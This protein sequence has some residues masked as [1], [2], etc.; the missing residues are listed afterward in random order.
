[1][2]ILPNIVYP[3]LV[4]FF[5]KELPLLLPR[6]QP[7]F[8]LSLCNMGEVVDYLSVICPFR[9]I[10]PLYWFISESFVPI[11]CRRSGNILSFLSVIVLKLRRCGAVSA[12]PIFYQVM[13]GQ[14]YCRGQGVPGSGSQ[15]G[16]VG[17]LTDSNVIGCLISRLYAA[18]CTF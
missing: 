6:A 9:V 11:F 18:T 4:R 16:G 2:G 13:S 15:G 8:F 3:L 10:C 14:E 1:M 7:P 12:R 5:F 17:T